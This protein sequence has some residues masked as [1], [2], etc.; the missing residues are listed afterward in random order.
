MALLPYPAV[1]GEPGKA[2]ID[3]SNVVRHCHQT[4]MVLDEDGLAL[5]RC[6]KVAAAA[7]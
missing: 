4:L 1:Q 5:T 6:V 3:L 2:M 7:P